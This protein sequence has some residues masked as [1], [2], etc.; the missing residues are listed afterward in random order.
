MEK[1]ERILKEA[2]HELPKE[3]LLRTKLMSIMSLLP[4]GQSDS[5]L[6]SFQTESEPM[7]EGMVGLVNSK[8]SLNREMKPFGFKKKGESSG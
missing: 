8:G 6:H 1:P 4:K 3:S 2:N 7:G 5:R